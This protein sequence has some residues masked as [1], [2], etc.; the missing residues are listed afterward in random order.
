[1]RGEIFVKISDAVVV[2]PVNIGMI[3]PREKMKFL[4]VIS[5]KY[6]IVGF[7]LPSVSTYVSEMNQ[8]R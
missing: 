3:K 5:Q 4:L 2:F 1:M 8:T 7:I 6:I